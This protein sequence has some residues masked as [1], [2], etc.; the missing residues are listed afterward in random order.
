MA[1]TEYEVVITGPCECC[2]TQCTCQDFVD[3]W[4]AAAPNPPLFCTFGACRHIGDH[5]IIVTACGLTGNTYTMAWG[6]TWVASGS[7]G[8]AFNTCT[9]LTGTTKG[10]NYSGAGPAPY[11]CIRI[12]LQNA[13]L[14]PG[15]G[16]DKCLRL[17]IGLAKQ[18]FGVNN[19]AGMGVYP[20]GTFFGTANYIP[21][22]DCTPDTIATWTQWAL[23]GTF[24]N[25]VSLPPP[26]PA[27]MC[28]PGGQVAVLADPPC[29]APSDN[30]CSY[31]DCQVTIFS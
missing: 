1:I 17:D 9:G 31:V 30:P 14:N 29:P 16:N 13:I 23:H 24:Y 6:T 8:S 18:G 21:G 7:Y 22:N 5:S 11:N 27:T 25:W 2:E 4:N 15:S 12:F 28:G 26:C 10:W 20:D 19:C 3:A